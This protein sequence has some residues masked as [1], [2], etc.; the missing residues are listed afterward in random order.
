MGVKVRDTDLKIP[1]IIP[2]LVQA[3]RVAYTTKRCASIGSGLTNIPG[4]GFR[5]GFPVAILANSSCDISTTRTCEH[6]NFQ[7]PLLLYTCSDHIPES[8]HLL[9]QKR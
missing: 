2:M 7:N 9:N 5:L 4:R 1:K 6:K 3:V 8:G